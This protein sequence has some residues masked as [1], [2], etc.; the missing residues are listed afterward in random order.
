MQLLGIQ[1]SDLSM[2][3]M[4]VVTILNFSDQNLSTSLFQLGKRLGRRF[5]IKNNKDEELYQAEALFQLTLICKDETTR[6]LGDR[7]IT[8]QTLLI[9]K[10]YR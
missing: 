1:T 3:Q 6:F 4:A 7:P 10:I 2:T 8:D 5:A 9:R